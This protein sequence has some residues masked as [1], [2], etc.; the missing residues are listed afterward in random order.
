MSV[1]IRQRIAA[2]EAELFQRS[3]YL[4]ADILRPR[5]PKAQLAREEHREALRSERESLLRQ[6]PITGERAGHMVL[7]RTLG[8]VYVRESV[9]EEPPEKFDR[10]NPFERF[11]DEMGWRHD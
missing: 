1:E 3:A 5:D 8:T 11:A 9:Y 10:S 4:P 2:I 7:N 6:L